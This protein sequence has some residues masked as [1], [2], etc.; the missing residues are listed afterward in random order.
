M[1]FAA[2]LMSRIGACDL[3]Y[4]KELTFQTHLPVRDSFEHVEKWLD[5]A[6]TNGYKSTV[7]VL[8]GNKSDMISKRVVGY[9]ESLALAQKRNLMFVCF[10]LSLIARAGLQTCR[11]IETSAK[12]STNIDNVFQV[13]VTEVFKLRYPEAKAAAEISKASSEQ[14]KVDLLIAFCDKE[15]PLSASDAAAIRQLLAAGAGVANCR[16]KSE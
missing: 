14:D 3:S 11:Y 10:T 8:V 6:G 9:D 5:D 15:K 2:F 7:T 4:V 13:A 16:G 1:R 12:S